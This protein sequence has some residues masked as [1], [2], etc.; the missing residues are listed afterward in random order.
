MG[1]CCAPNCKGNCDTGP[2]ER[3][4]EWRRGPE[5][6]SQWQRAVRRSD[7]DVA[8]L[9]DPLV[10]ECLFK[11][12]Y[13]RTTTKYTDCDGRTIE[14][15]MKLTRLTR[16]AVPTIFPDS[17]DYLSDTQQ[18]REEPGM[19]KK[20]RE[21]EQLRKAIEES[22]LAHKKELEENKL[23]CLDDWSV[24]NADGHVIFTHIEATI[25]EAPN[26]I[27][28]IVISSDMSVRV[29]VGGA[30]LTSDE[31]LGIPEA[32]H[33]MRVLVQLLDGVQEYCRRRELGKN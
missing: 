30:R 26:L 1:R 9:K 29:F 11:E 2:K 15:K 8:K 33:D 28:S 19:N 18:S 31:R 23:T 21:D 3:L 7:I 16:D 24:V 5:R 17:P 6:R 25:E 20:R 10:Y 14:V 4:F 12:E 22:I 32:V 27:P 13:L